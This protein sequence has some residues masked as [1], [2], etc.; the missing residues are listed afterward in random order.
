MGTTETSGRS[1]TR[2]R[3]ERDFSEGN[4]RLLE[5]DE[6]EVERVELDRDAGGERPREPRLERAL[7]MEREDVQDTYE[8]SEEELE[9]LVPPAEESSDT[10]NTPGGGVGGRPLSPSIDSSMGVNT[11]ASTRRG[12]LELGGQRKYSTAMS[13][14][15]PRK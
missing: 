4:G 10:D 12:L 3:F 15:S 6:A 5:V 8:K 13:S 1:V 11:G 9:R 7:R 2:R 14:Q